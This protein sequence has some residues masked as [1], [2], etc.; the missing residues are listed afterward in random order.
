[1][2]R[3]E[4]F[5]ADGEKHLFVCKKRQMCA[6]VPIWACSRMENYNQRVIE[7]ALTSVA[8]SNIRL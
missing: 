1:M 2:P 4:Q 8:K 7:K 6:K 5:A 3:R